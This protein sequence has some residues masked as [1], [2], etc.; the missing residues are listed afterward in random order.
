[1][2]ARFLL[3]LLLAA[4]LA[5][6]TWLRTAT[7]TGFNEPITLQPVAEPGAAPPPGWSVEG[8]WRYDS[9]GRLFG[10]FSAL[11][12]LDDSH[13]RAFSDRGATFTFVSPDRPRPPDRAGSAIRAAPRLSYQSTDKAFANDLWDIES[14]ARDPTTGRFWLGYENTHAIQRFTAASQP[15]GVR[16]LGDEV[17]WSVNS[18]AE[19]MVRLADGRFLVIPE[20]GGEALLYPAD[21]VSGVKP[22]ALRYVPPAG[23]FGITDAAQLPDGR[24]MLLLRRVSWSLPT[25]DGRIAIAALPRAGQAQE[26]RPAIALDLTAVIPRDNYE[27]L[28]LRER[29]DGAVDVWVLSDDNFSVIQRTLLARLRFDPAAAAGSA[30]SA[31]R[32]SA[33]RSKQKARE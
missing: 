16:L 26:L 25:F 18:G 30:G 29:S 12:A 20:S 24:I 31:V 23:K 17:E 3:I 32:A 8:L 13:L 27:G 22:M 1:M 28:A 14:A 15:D 5:P 7:S 10:G 4:A 33:T 21:P 19:A 6:G 9:E 11:L 2:R